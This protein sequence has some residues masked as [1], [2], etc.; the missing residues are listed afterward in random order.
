MSETPNIPF[1]KLQSAAEHQTC[2]WLKVQFAVKLE[3]EAQSHQIEPAINK[4]LR[5]LKSA[6]DKRIIKPQTT[7]TRKRVMYSWRKFYVATTQ[8]SRDDAGIAKRQVEI[9]L[10]HLSNK[11]MDRRSY[12]VILAGNINWEQGTTVYNEIKGHRLKLVDMMDSSKK[13]FPKPS[14]I[15]VSNGLETPN[16]ELSDQV[17]S[18]GF[19]NI[20]AATLM[21]KRSGGEEFSDHRAVFAAVLPEDV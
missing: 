6:T 17:W 5:L 21:D 20:L 8:L 4:L 12:P 1:T 2:T 18:S 19:T 16:A 7:V 10:D 15:N 11:I 9:L 13:S 14:V 3:L